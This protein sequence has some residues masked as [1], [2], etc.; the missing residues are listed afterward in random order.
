MFIHACVYEHTIC[1]LSKSSC[2][3][4]SFENP[5][6]WLHLLSV[7]QNF[8]IRLGTDISKT[9]SCSG[10]PVSNMNWGPTFSGMDQDYGQPLMDLRA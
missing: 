10:S 3:Q 5:S 2:Y 1:T 9:H 4:G 6:F 8:G 7:S